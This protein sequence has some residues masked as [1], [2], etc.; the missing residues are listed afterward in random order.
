MPIPCSNGMVCYYYN[1]QLRSIIV[2]NGTEIVIVMLEV[3]AVFL[4]F[5]LPF[6]VRRIWLTTDA[7]GFILLI[8]LLW[9]ATVYTTVMAL[10]RWSIIIGV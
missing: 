9:F 10:Y 2:M 8:T 3:L 4:L 7:I 5:G 1:R 6:L